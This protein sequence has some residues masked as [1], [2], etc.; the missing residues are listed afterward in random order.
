[1]ERI[2]I[3]Q[4]SPELINAGKEQ[5]APSGSGKSWKK[6]F[7]VMQTPVNQKIL[8]WMPDDFEARKVEMLVHDVMQGKQ[9]AQF[10]CINGLYE[11]FEQFGY[12][13][14]CPLCACVQDS[15]EQYNIKLD[16]KAR[17][18]GVDRDN[19][20]DN[21]LKGFKD[22]LLKEMAVKN[23]DKYVCFP[24]VAIPCD[25]MGN[26][27][28]TSGTPVQ[29]YY[30]V[31]RKQRYEDKFSSDILESR[32]SPAGTF[33]RWSFTY[34]TK[35]QQATAMLSAKALKVKIIENPEQLAVLNQ[36]LE[37]CKQVIAPFDQSNAVDAVKACNFL[38]YAALEHE[39]EKCI[40]STRLFLSANAAMQSTVGNA[41]ALGQVAP[42]AP[43]LG[44]SSAEAAIANFGQANVAQTGAAPAPAP[45][46]GIAPQP[47]GQVAPAQ[48]A[49]PQGI[50]PTPMGQ[51]APT[52]MG[53][54]APQ[55]MGQV[56][57]TPM[58][59]VA[60]TQTAPV[61]QV[62]PAPT[63]M[64]Q[65][66]PPQAAPAQQ[67]IPTAPQPPVFGQAAPTPPQFGQ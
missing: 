16:A 5:E 62:A 66:A 51:V 58:G 31:W 57:P 52:P 64:G 19:D 40:K 36:F 21:I 46:Q 45:A 63:Q 18:L 15:W 23:P 32:T 22:N 3:N 27:D 35:G 55:P 49:A 26:P 11:G 14:E 56:A 8:I 50:A 38:T 53:Q 47:M 25:K 10:R 67:P 9:Y 7:P 20:P 33:Q 48:Q 43:Q 59:Q 12:T 42:A 13:G 29:P 6:E 60:P 41:P 37:S 44:T 1:M 17:E 28:L 65:V 54:A 24:V 61:G 2:S 34:D 4:L 30:V 39:A